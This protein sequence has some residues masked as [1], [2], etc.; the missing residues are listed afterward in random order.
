MSSLFLK[1]VTKLLRWITPTPADIEK[2]T[3]F[4]SNN[5]VTKGDFSLISSNFGLFFGK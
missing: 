1:K 3:Q 4:G 2:N 5:I